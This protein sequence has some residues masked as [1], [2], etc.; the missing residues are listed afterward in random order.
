LDE[1]EEI[2]MEVNY[3]IVQLDYNNRIGNLDVKASSSV[4]S[5]KFFPIYNINNKTYIFKPLSK[6]KPLTTNLFSY[7][8][9]F[10]STVTNIFYPSPIYRLAICHGYEE[11]EEKYYDYGT[12]V[13]SILNENEH[14]VNLYEWF[15]SNPDDKVDI[16]DYIN[17]CM[18]AYDY[19]FILEAKIFKENKALG[20]ALVRQILMSILKADQNFHY[21]NV[22][23]VCNEDG[24]ILRLAESIDH[25][26]SNF[27]LFPEFLAD[28]IYFQVE[29][30]NDGAVLNNIKYIRENYVDV[31]NDFKKKL[32][33][34]NNDIENGRF[35]ISIKD[36]CFLDEPCSSDKWK[37][38]HELYKN[39][40]RE[41]AISL[42]KMLNLTKINIKDFNQSLKMNI[43]RHIK[44][45]LFQ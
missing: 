30:E 42:E 4:K 40:D 6:T 37:V 12:I 18:K 45:L 17:Y 36:T 20:E 19:T 33:D 26:F 8:E 44:W 15:S 41:K 27:F 16:K 9:V 21:E 13:P 43:Q 3:E 10:W 11:N 38:G 7:S 1:K 28:N 22:A 31:Y 5:N 32:E 2:S 24:K 35:N 29:Y 23:F 14:L 39:N 34:W 25:E